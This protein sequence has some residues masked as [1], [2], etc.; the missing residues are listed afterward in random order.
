MAEELKCTS[1]NCQVADILNH[2]SLSGS[3]LYPWA[4][5]LPLSVAQFQDGEDTYEAIGQASHLEATYSDALQQ[6]VE[7]GGAGT[8][9]L[10]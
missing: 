1:F 8:S 10:R 6:A 5:F 2:R 9:E 4:A 3:R 7:E